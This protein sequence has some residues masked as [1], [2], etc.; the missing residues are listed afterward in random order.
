MDK[1]CTSFQEFQEQNKLQMTKKN[2]FPPIKTKK[3]NF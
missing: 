2:V 1:K 3:L